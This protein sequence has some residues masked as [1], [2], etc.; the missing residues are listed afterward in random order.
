MII[1]CGHGKY[2]EAMKH[3]L[4][5]IAGEQENIKSID[6]TMDMA[7]GDILTQYNEAIQTRQSDEEVLILCDI[8]GGSPANAAF[9]AKK[10]NENVRVATGL[11]L[12]MA[13]SI[14][15]GESFENALTNAKEAIQEI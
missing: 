3:S 6:F 2:G 12:A 5:M 15:M 13:L 14:A 8:P 10:Y 9:L 7:V 11:C 4:E 1:F